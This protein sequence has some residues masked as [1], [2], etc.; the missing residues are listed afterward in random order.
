MCVGV[1]VAVDVKVGEA[2]HV[3]VTGRKA[4]GEGVNVCVAVG[5]NV[6]VS[7]TTSGVGL[8]VGNPKVGVAVAG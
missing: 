2:V 4:V 3:E 5:V 1:K 6:G 8:R 7:V